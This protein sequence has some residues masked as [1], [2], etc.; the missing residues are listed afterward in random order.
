MLTGPQVEKETHDLSDQLDELREQIDALTTEKKEIEKHLKEC[1]ANRERLSTLDG[2]LRGKRIQLETKQENIDKLERNIKI[3]SE[4]DSE[5]QQMVDDFEARVESLQSQANEHKKQY[6]ELQQ[7]MQKTRN[8]LS[9]KERELGSLTA[10]KDNYERQLEVREKLVKEIA[11][12][13]GIRGF[14]LDVN[15]ERVIAFK[16][17]MNGLKRDQTRALESARRKT[18]EELQQ[19]QAVLSGINEKKT[20]FVQR[21][22]NAR[23]TITSNDKK[24]GN[25]QSDYDRIEVDE[26]AKAAIESFISDSQS[27]LRNSK[28]S[29]ESA[30]W[31]EKIQQLNA[32]LSTLDE[33]KEKLDAELAEGAKRAGE[34]ARLEYLHKEVRDGETSLK[35]MINTHGDKIK[36]LLN[37]DWSISHLENDFQKTLQTKSNLVTEAERQRDGVSNELAQ[38]NYKLSDCRKELKKKNQQGGKLKDTITDT[39]GTDISE[40]SN[41]LTEVEQES[42]AV[43]SN[44]SAYE[45]MIEYFEKSIET[46]E[47]HSTCRLCTRAFDGKKTEQVQKF[48]AR[49]QKNIKN[50]QE[51]TA[52]QDAEDVQ[53]ELKALRALAPSHDTWKRLSETEIPAAEQE[54]KRLQSHKDQL[55]A[56]IERYDAVVAERQSERTDVE[57]L[58]STIKSMVK[59]HTDVAAHQRQIKELEA[60]QVNPGQLRTLDQINEDIKSIAE[61][62]RAGKTSLNKV[63]ADRDRALT[64][65]NALELEIRDLRSRLESTDYKL[66]EKTALQRQIGDL[67]A[68]N[69]EQREALTSADQNIQALGPE[70]G[71]AQ[72]SY[73]EVARRGSEKDAELREKVA[74]LDRSLNRIQVAEQE[75][76]AYIDRDGPTQLHRAQYSIDSMK[77]EITSIEQ[78]VTQITKDVKNIENQLRN[79]EDT[80]RSI[81]DNLDYRRDQR[82]IEKV[83]AEIGEL[84]SHNV[85]GEK[86]RWESEARHW[87]NERLKNNANQ[88]RIVGQMQEKDD[89]LKKNYADWETDYKDA[90]QKY[91]EAHIRVETTKAAVEDL[92]RYGGALENA[93]MKYHTIKMEEVNRIIGELWNRT[94]QG[95][96]V[97][98]IVIKSENESLKGGKSYKYRVCMVKQDAEMDMRGRCSAGQKV[99]ASIIIRLAL[100]ECFGVNCGL[101]ALDEPTTNLDRDNIQ[102]LARAL[103]EIIRV[104]RQQS[105]FQLIVITHDEEFLRYMQCSDYA[106]EYYRVSRDANQDTEI[107]RQSIG[108]VS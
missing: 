85:E 88:S 28:A 30:G 32:D 42:D 10:Q 94:Y 48:I 45:G 74:G 76:N 11:R 23:A 37:P 89:R 80:K 97:D 101:I 24:I 9:S 90:P 29:F 104:R 83:S 34:V 13:H 107:T 91:K 98:T 105:N 15:D 106:D 14:D 92:G 18:N 19:A 66:K 82:E 3:M 78:Q 108:Y 21:K 86:G 52:N 1:Y 50:Y 53:R 69:T 99:L 2:D 22:E 27:R 51:Q 79:N 54:E 72:A 64:A 68:S 4:P 67:K 36:G 60:K 55:D 59:Y 70:L 43:M 44:T 61:K 46:A 87:E 81:A 49:L 96:D 5:L 8:S 65:I 33:K 40:F 12:S 20:G 102:A 38:V 47:Q 103:S 62:S 17:K 71:Q 25:L 35:S 58:A 39:L 63:T 73:D 41:R 84:E 16:E 56:D 95:T 75:I 6:A 93:V 7:Q 77:S 31:D 26:G 57:S 100:A